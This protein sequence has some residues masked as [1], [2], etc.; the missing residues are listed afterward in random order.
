M[1]AGEGPCSSSISS[2]TSSARATRPAPEAISTPASAITVPSRDAYPLKIALSRPALAASSSPAFLT[3]IS[4]RR[5]C[6]ECISFPR[7][8]SGTR[9]RNGCWPI[10]SLALLRD[11]EAS[12]EQTRSPGNGKGVV[13]LVIPWRCAATLGVDHEI[14]RTR[15]GRSCHRDATPLQRNAM[16][17]A[18]PQHNAAGAI[19]AEVSVMA[20]CSPS[21]SR[22]E[23][24]GN[25]QKPMWRRRAVDH[26]ASAALGFTTSQTEDYGGTEQKSCG[27]WA[28]PFL[29]GVLDLPTATTV[30]CDRTK[31]R[32]SPGDNCL[33]ATVLCSAQRH[34]CTSCEILQS[35]GRR[36][37]S[38]CLPPADQVRPAPLHLAQW[39][40]NTFA[41]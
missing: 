35:L 34:C 2:S 11:V 10:P 9:W 41:A 39:S 33:P 29:H 15:G 7:Q 16:M 23:G 8:W 17:L 38:L 6:S 4:G 14:P 30:Q 28:P 37:I 3:W 1:A 21:S 31:Q 12:R 5:W 27:M 32:G 19:R 22:L 20:F 13:C 26:G 18:G 25:A 40:P 36:R 24:D